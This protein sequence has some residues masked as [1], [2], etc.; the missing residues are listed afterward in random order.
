MDINS[1]PVSDQVINIL[2]EFIDKEKKYIYS[3]KQIRNLFTLQQKEEWL[4]SNLTM[5]D[6]IEKNK[7]KEIAQQKSLEFQE[8]Q[9]QY[10]LQLLEQRKIKLQKQYYDEYYY[11]NLYYSDDEYSTDQYSSD[12][13]Y[14]SESE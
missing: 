10:K 13:E 4:H 9:K 11:N 3:P 1:S 12:E 8:Q 2:G 6:Y 7:L 5:E 14:Y